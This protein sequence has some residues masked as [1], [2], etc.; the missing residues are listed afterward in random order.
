[1]YDIILYVFVCSYS[2]RLC[3]VGKEII[4]QIRNHTNEQMNRHFFASCEKAVA[5]INEVNKN[6]FIHTWFYLGNIY[7]ERDW[8][9]A[10]DY[11]RAKY[12]ILQRKK[13][14]D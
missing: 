12:M 11:I 13:H 1:M 8:G 5:C 6:L 9:H 2:E 7:S 3:S 4:R 14:E 10:K